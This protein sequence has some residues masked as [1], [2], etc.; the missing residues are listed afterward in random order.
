LYELIWRRALASQMPDA[1]IDS[2]TVDIAAGELSLRANGQVITFDGFQAAYGAVSE[3]TKLPVLAEG[4]KLEKEKV[5]GVQH[6]TQPPPRFSDASIV[7]AMEELGIGR[8][9]TYAPTISTIQERGYVEKIEK[10]FQPTE[11]GTLVNDVLVKHF[12]QIV[13]LTFTSTMEEDLDKVAT[14]EREWVPVISEFYGPFHKNLEAKQAEV[15]KESLVEQKTDETCEK[16]G[17]PMI[18]KFGRFGKFLACTGYP[19]C[20]TTRP[21]KEEREAQEKM[22][23]E[24]ANEKCPECGSPMQ[25]KRGRFGVFLGCTKYPECKGIKRIDK[26]TGATCPE[27]SKGEIVE[28]R[29]KAGRTFYSCN[30]YPECKYAMWNKPT[31]KKCPTCQSLLVFAAKG[32]IKCSSKTCDYETTENVE[33]KPPTE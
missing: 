2:T 13:D 14:G 3:E 19:D 18:V 6:F 9:S 1:K 8:P 27:C 31:G 28:R 26:K 17:K 22:A 4:D 7:K 30:R 23:A 24:Y 32:K 11:I 5:S 33:V 15:T 25:V 29:S 20:K 10:K 21:L 16:C 12:P